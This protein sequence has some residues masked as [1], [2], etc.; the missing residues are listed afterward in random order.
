MLTSECVISVLLRCRGEG[1]SVA[2]VRGAGAD[3][4]RGREVFRS[5]RPDAG[6]PDKEH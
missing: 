3:H 5:S 6:A 4:V 2:T 1:Y